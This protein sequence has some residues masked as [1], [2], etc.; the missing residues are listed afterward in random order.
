M[1]SFSKG[2]QVAKDFHDPK[3]VAGYDQHIRKLI[4]AYA[5]MHAQV[6]AA[7]TLHLPAS[8]HLL[9]VGCGTGYEVQYLLESFPNLAITAVDPSQ[10]MLQ[11]AQQNIQALA[12]ANRVRFV[13]GTTAD[14]DPTLQF[15]AA[16]SLLVAHFIPVAEKLD[17]FREIYRHLK[18]HALLMTYDM[19]LP[20]NENELKLLQNLCIEQGLTYRQTE[21]MLARLDSDF[22]L[23]TVS[24]QREILQQAGFQNIDTYLQVIN[25]FGFLATK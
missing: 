6:R 18:P 21:Q 8:A 12:G 25:Y 13:H 5:L 11:Q 23:I 20:N 4:P 24:S 15:D 19:F 22:C 10:N 17:S 3:V 9:I 14:L 2:T 1:G 7:L 16:L